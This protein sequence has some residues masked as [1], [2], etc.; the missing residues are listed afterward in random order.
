MLRRQSLVHLK[1]R[2]KFFLQAA[3]AY[4]QE[5]HA[6]AQYLAAQGHEQNNLYFA[7]AQIAADNIFRAK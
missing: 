6:K 5:D 3:N 2:N 7:E 1:K 4:D